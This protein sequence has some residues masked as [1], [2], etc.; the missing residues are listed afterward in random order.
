MAALVDHFDH[1]VVPVDDV[2]AA[3]T[4]YTEV[5]GAQIA[6]RAN[7]VQM[8][9]GLNLKEFLGG[10]RPHTFF[11]L[12]GKRIGVYLQCEER[13]KADS[14]YGGPTYSFETTAAGLERVAAE[15]AKR[16]I[17]CEGP[18]D[19]DGRPATRSL[20]FN[21]PAGNHYHVYV[22]AQGSQVGANGELTAVGYL[23]LEAPQLDESIRFYRTAFGFDEPA[24]GANPRLGVREARFRLPS[25]QL[26]VLSE[27]PYSPKGIKSG[28]DVPGPHLAFFVPGVRWPTLYE[29]LAS[30]GIRNGDVLP[31]LKH[32]RGGELDTYLCDPA[33]YRLQLVGEGVE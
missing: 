5:L 18:A 2:L 12:A 23:R 16:G 15:L 26:F 6:V 9:V 32:R 27:L 28:W 1:F 20:F 4:F 25:G 17:P 21:D 22:P 11:K 14:V 10:M 30:L 19:D 13:P 31:E 33:G 3:E 8:R 24:F 7:G 29:R